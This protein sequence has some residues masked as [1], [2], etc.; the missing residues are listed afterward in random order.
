DQQGKRLNLIGRNLTGTLAGSNI[1]YSGYITDGT[2]PDLEEKAVNL[3]TVGSSYITGTFNGK[4]A[5]GTLQLS[6]APLHALVAGVLGEM[7]GTAYATGF[8]RYEIPVENLLASSVKMDFVPLEISGGGDTLIGKGRLIYSNGNL[9]FDDLIL[10]GKGEWRIDGHYAKD[11]VDLNFV[12]KDTV[13]TPIL[14]L[15]PLVQEYNPKA[16]GSLEFK[17]SG[18]YGKPDASLS[19]KDLTASISGISLTAKEL[20]GTLQSGD[21][22][23]RGVL[24]S[25]ESLGATL[26]TTAKAKLISYTP[27]QL[28]GLE[29]LATGSLNIKPVGFIDQVNARIFGDSGGFK[30]AVTAKKGGN[31]SITGEIS[32]RLKLKLEGQQLVMPIPEYFIG[33]SLLDAVLTFE[34]DG[35]RFYDV[36]GKLNIARLQTQLQQNNQDAPTTKPTTT[37]SSK[38][39][40]FLQQVRFRGLEINAPQGIRISESFATLEAGGRLSLTGTMGSPEFSGQLEALGNSG[41]R[42]TVR[43]GINTYNIQTAIAAF[44]PIE[45]I[46]PSIQLVSK[47]LVQK[48]CKKDGLQPKDLT[49]ELVIRVRWLPDSKNPTIKKIDIQPSVAGNCPDAYDQLN[50]AEL[51]SLVTLGSSNA[52]LSG[53]A[54]QSLDTVLSV[55][56]ISELTRQIKAATGID[57]DFSSNLI[58]AVAQTIADPTAQAT[59]NFTLNFGIDLSRN[60]RLNLQLNNRYASSGLGGEIGLNIQSEDGQ[61]G[62]RF[63]TPFAFS[64]PD[65]LQTT[66]PEIQFSWNFAGNFGLNFTGFFLPG[67]QT[68]T[69]GLKF[70]VSWR[71]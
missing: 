18:Q 58:E 49:V 40:P 10:R 54:Q 52:N 26:D 15:L 57:I 13:F 55:F 66:R 63:S 23:V 21:L 2:I 12:F 51:Y 68:P 25:D 29:A 53:L 61:F 7:P 47:G 20:V 43:L 34:G 48:A 3:G 70:G 6:R 36:A 59:V 67:Q 41:G 11:I 30:A 56:V 38:P 1:R 31:L 5:T 17:L 14:N 33:D 50:P 39:N 32:P 62:V 4:V 46:F 44:S 60:L 28:E 37:T 19:L 71:F 9:E 69:V 16:S 45:G 22:Q 35:G 64:S 27:I 24:I 8:A 42:G 65:F